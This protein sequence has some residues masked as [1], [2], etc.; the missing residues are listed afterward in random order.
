MSFLSFA[1]LI[2]EIDVIQIDYPRLLGDADTLA[3][4]VDALTGS[5]LMRPL[6]DADRNQIL[7]WL[8]DEYAEAEDTA[9]PAGIPE[10]IAPLV[11]AV[12]VS[13]AYFQ[14]R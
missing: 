10:Q 8:V 3:G 7:A 14:L 12:L 6:S 1:N 11:A 9:L 4:I 13:S 5:I 2:P